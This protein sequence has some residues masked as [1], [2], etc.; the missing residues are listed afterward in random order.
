MRGALV[1]V[2]VLGS[3][4]VEVEILGLRVVKIVGLRV[5]AFCL[6]PKYKSNGGPTMVE[7]TVVLVDSPKVVVEVVEVLGLK[8]S[9]R[10]IVMAAKWQWCSNCT[11]GD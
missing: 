4:V 7:G 6:R 10:G 8:A 2:E 5:L 9:G 3:R 1:V 11:A